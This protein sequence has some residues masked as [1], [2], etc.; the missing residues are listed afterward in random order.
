MSA[1][2]ARLPASKD[3]LEVYRKAQEADS[4]CSQLLHFC[5]QGWPNKHQIKGDLSHYWAVRDE[6][7]TCDR[8]LLYGSRIIVPESLRLQTLQKQGHQ[9]LIKSCPEANATSEGAT[10]PDNTPL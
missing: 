7:T 8:L 9:G 10:A 3:R 2:V 1:L 6:I 5:K 4:I